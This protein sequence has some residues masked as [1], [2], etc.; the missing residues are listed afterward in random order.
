[1][2]IHKEIYKDVEYT[3]DYLGNEDYIL[4]TSLGDECL[5]DMDECFM[6]M[7]WL[8]KENILK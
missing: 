8:R 2:R 1:M 5:G 4:K 3:I 7:S 6:A